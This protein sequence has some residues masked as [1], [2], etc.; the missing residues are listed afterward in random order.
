MGY[1][2]YKKLTKVNYTHMSNKKNEYIVIH[3][4]GN[5][6]DTALANARYFETVN[7]DA[8]AN[9]FVD[10]TTVY[11]CV[12]DSDK[13]WHVGVNYGNHTLFGKCTNSNSI[14]IE[15]CSNKKKI[16]KGTYN[17]TVALTKKLMKKY[18]I[19][20]S[21]VVRHYDVCNKV[22]PGWSGWTRKNDKIWK[23]FKKDIQ[24]TTSVSSSTT[25]SKND[26]V[27]SNKYTYDKFMSDLKVTLGLKQ[28]AG[29]QKVFKNTITISTTK[30]NK[31]KAILPVKKY[32]NSL[33]YTCGTSNAVAGSNFDTA[34]KAFQKDKKLCIDGEITAKKDTWKALLKIK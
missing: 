18:N 30:N 28:P 15:M 24:S 22:C 11:Q 7:R 20:A 21:R 31:H 14:G 12:L 25:S 9:Y 2:L 10:Q 5:T 27:I 1:K 16:A 26:S 34:V 19:P 6:T 17:N 23:Q 3:Y 32:L 13:A 8:S 33:G 4:T 29:K